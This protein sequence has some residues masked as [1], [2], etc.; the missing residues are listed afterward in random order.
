M[1]NTPAC[2]GTLI[3]LFALTAAPFLNGCGDFWQAPT[4]S[5]GTTATTTTLTASTTTRWSARP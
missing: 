1:K 3:L 5:G 4:G 2:S